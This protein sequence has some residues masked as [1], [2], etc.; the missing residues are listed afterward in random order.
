MYEPADSMS[1]SSTPWNLS[2]SEVTP[3]FNDGVPP[4]YPAMTVVTS[5]R[6]LNTLELLLILPNVTVD[7][8]PK[9][10]TGVVNVCDNELASVAALS[11]LV[12][13]V[14]EEPEYRYNAYS[15]SPESSTCAWSPVRGVSAFLAAILATTV[16]PPP[17]RIPFSTFRPSA[18]E[19]E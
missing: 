5:T 17:L 18:Y 16:I 4:V 13:N 9:P 8:L 14:Q 2:G 11:S 10:P 6:T 15:P 3:T 12:S 7:V 1:F 19:P